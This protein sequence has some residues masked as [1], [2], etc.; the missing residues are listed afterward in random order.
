MRLDM[1]G[2][3]QRRN[4]W[5]PSLPSAVRLPEAPT[6]PRWLPRHLLRPYERPINGNPLLKLPFW[7][8]HLRLTHPRRTHPNPRQW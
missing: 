8:T 6:V 4:N 5:K 3:S 1:N 7:L 2:L